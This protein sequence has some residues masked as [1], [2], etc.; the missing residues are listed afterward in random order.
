MKE[1]IVKVD[2]KYQSALIKMWRATV[3]ILIKSSFNKGI[4]KSKLMTIVQYTPMIKRR[5]DKI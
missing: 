2:S 1:K 4:N 3:G 5:D